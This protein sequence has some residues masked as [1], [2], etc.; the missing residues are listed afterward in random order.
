VSLNRL[1]QKIGIIGG[2][3]L[4]KM[5]CQAGS[6]FGLDIS[7]MDKDL[8]Y[9]TAQICRDYV[10]GDINIYEDV[11]AFGS[12]KDIITIE[13]EN[14]NVAAL[15]TLEKM[16]K[17]VFPKP[18]SLKII[19]DKGLQKEFYEA[20]GFPTS[21]YRLYKDKT[22]IL[23]AI[24]DGKL[25]IPFVQ[26]LRSDGYDGKGVHVVRN[27]ADLA[28]LMDGACLTENIVDIDKEIAVIVGRTVH[29][30]VMPFPAVEMH[31]HPTANLVEYLFCPSS[32]NEELAKQAENLA[33]QIAH[34]MDIVGLLAV[35]MFVTKDGNLLVNEVA[36]RPHNS[37]H[38]TIE[39]CVTSQYEMHLRAILDLP[40]GDP[41]LKKPAVMVNLL[42]ENGYS[43]PVNYQGMVECLNISGVYPH[44]YGK[45]E[46]KPFR[47]MGHVTIVEN[48][49]EDAIIK[50]K[51]VQN[52]LKVI[53]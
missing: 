50:A 3:Q 13:I 45:K 22:E 37:G 8:S 15:E 11:L 17:S 36:P 41:S 52:T 18:A 35:E 31:F 25:N 49:L 20:S 2:G 6:K 7:V 53:S 14:I 28:Y 47:K 39:A 16:G 19:R 46:T 5:L 44:L 40:L 4:G 34:K 48:S 12:D 27:D 10:C 30:V 24:S 43:G 38:H 51:F 1:S 33:I 29:G 32:I 26:K 21:P 9:P 23:Q 42:G